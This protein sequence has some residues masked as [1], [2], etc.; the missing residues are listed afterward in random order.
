MS[1]SGEFEGDSAA[2]ELSTIAALPVVTLMALLYLDAS[3][4]LIASVGYVGGIVSCGALCCYVWTV[5]TP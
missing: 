5:T 3:P 4:W 2:L 1:E